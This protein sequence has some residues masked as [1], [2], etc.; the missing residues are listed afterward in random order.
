MS[1]KFTS[2]ITDST[3][4]CQ[5]HELKEGIKVMLV[6]DIKAIGPALAALRNSMQVKASKSL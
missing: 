4:H 6:E 5:V 2:C 3:L 1:T